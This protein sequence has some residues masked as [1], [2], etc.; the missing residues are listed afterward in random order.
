MLSV[1]VVC[2]GV[3]EVRSLIPLIVGAG[4]VLGPVSVVL[5][6]LTLEIVAPPPVSRTLIV[7]VAVV[8][9]SAVTVGMLVMSIV[10]DVCAKALKTKIRKESVKASVNLFIVDPPSLLSLD[11]RNLFISLLGGCPVLKKGQKV[12]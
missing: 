8:P 9:G 1:N 12:D 11:S 10:G 4:M 2:L 7:K 6:K 3:V 5:V